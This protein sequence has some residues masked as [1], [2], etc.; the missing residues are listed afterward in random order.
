[1]RNPASAAVQRERS[2]SWNSSA[3]VRNVPPSVRWIA[4]R[5]ICE[6]LTAARACAAE[7]E[8]AAFDGTN[9][10]GQHRAQVPDTLPVQST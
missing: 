10:W 5:T 8:L 1:M 2:E 7:L 9:D 4:P 6:S 3:L